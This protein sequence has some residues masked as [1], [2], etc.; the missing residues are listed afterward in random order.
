MRSMVWLVAGLENVVLNV[1]TNQMLADLTLVSVAMQ[2]RK[3]RAPLRVLGAPPPK[4]GNGAGGDPGQGS[5]G[6]GGGRPR[7]GGVWITKEEIAARKAHKV[8]IWCA[9]EGHIG[10]DCSNEKTAH[11]LHPPKN[12][13]LL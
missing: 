11:P 3:E 4:K 9:K 8:C 2:A 10:K 12:A 1:L 6:G 5:S 7:N 13:H